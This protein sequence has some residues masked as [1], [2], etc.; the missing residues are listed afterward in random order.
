MVSNDMVIE[1]KQCLPSLLA[2]DRSYVSNKTGEK[3]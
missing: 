2:I 1:N 3:N